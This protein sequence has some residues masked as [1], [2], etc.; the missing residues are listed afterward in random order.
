MAIIFLP[1][2]ALAGISP[3]RGESALVTLT[4][5]RQAHNLFQFANLNIYEVAKFLLSPLVGEMSRSDRGG[6]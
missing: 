4:A 6:Y 1:P 3:T 5:N 2:S